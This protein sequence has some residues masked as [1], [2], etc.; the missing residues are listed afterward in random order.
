MEYILE[1]KYPIL[2]TGIYTWS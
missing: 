1:Y 2:K